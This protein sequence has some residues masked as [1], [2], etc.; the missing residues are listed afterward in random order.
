MAKNSEKPKRRFSGVDELPA[1]RA[2]DKTCR[3]CLVLEGGAFRGVYT[4]G[5]L[6]AFMENDLNFEC[7]VGV[8]AGA[9]NSVNYVS[10]QIGRNGR[11]NLTFRHDKRYVGGLK[12]YRANRGIIGFDFVFDTVNKYLPFDKARFDTRENMRLIAV[13]SNL[14]TGQPIYFEKGVCSDFYKAVSASASMPYV[15]KPVIVDGVPCLDGGCTDKIPYKWGL[16]NGYDKVVVVKT[17]QDEYRK[18]I[19]PRRDKTLSK[20]FYKKYPLFSESLAASN[21]NYNTQCDEIEELR[22]QGKIFVVSPS[23]PLTVGRLEKD[24]EKLGEWYYLGYNDGIAAVPAIKE[25]LGI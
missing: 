16:D 7:T 24:M 2:S 6:D 1:G 3:G 17:R 15:S 5:V 10:G 4:S 22:S 8:S 12:T 18:K 19:K 23:G 13:C 14:E 20:L 11:I 21:F 9:L 25:Y